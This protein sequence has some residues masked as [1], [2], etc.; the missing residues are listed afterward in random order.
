MLNLTT[1]HYYFNFPFYISKI[2]YKIFSPMTLDNFTK[3]IYTL[4]FG[5]T[6]STMRLCFD[7]FNTKTNNKSEVIQLN[8]IKAVLYHFH[9]HSTTNTDDFE[10][11]I[12]NI[13]TNSFGNISPEKE[14][15]YNEWK[16]ICLK[17]N[18]DV[19]TLMLFYLYRGINVLNEDILNFM[20]KLKPKY[21]TDYVI[22]NAL[23]WGATPKGSSTVTSTTASSS[24]S[25]SNN[26]KELNIEVDTSKDVFNLIKNTQG[27]NME[28]IEE[29]DGNL[30]VNSYE[31]DLETLSAFEEDKKK[32]LTKFT[33][34]CMGL[35]LEPD[36]KYQTITPQYNV[37]DTIIANVNFKITQTLVLPSEQKK[38][39]NSLHGASNI[40][41]SEY[42]HKYE[43]FTYEHKKFTKVKLYIIHSVIFV[44][45]LDKK[46]I[47]L[48]S[49]TS[50][51]GNLAIVF[52]KDNVKLKDGKYYRLKLYQTYD[53]YFLDREKGKEMNRVVCKKLNIQLSNTESNTSTIIKGKYE[54][55]LFNPVCELYN[56][57]VKIYLTKDIYDTVAVKSGKEL[58]VKAITKDA[59]GID[60]N[61]EN[62]YFELARQIITLNIKNGIDFG[63]KPYDKYETAH[64][65]YLIYFVN[66]TIYE[67][68]DTEMAKLSYMKAIT[69]F[70]YY[71]NIFNVCLNI[72]ELT[73]PIKTI[74]S[75]IVKSL[76]RNKST[77]FVNDGCFEEKY[78]KKFV[79]GPPEVLKGEKITRKVDVWWLGNIFYYVLFNK[80]PFNVPD[81]E[82][83]SKRNAKLYQMIIGDVGKLIEEGN[84]DNNNN[85]FTTKMQGL[86]NDMLKV[87]SQSRISIKQI[88]ENIKAFIEEYKQLSLADSQRSK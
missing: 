43:C 61:M 22:F 71:L 79:Y 19:F 15:T 38:L 18:S 46:L 28:Y 5:N 63:I 88:L 87:D 83:E 17:K 73:L 25:S 64:T 44:L 10:T 29:D 1:F 36:N 39:F 75:F 81:E 11:I 42:I 77:K 20:N 41:K 21:P 58:Y 68:I 65:L 82:E 14:I 62:A 40:S 84:N 85:E 66:D 8:N 2:L 45:S 74:K 13:I 86:I 35:P 12:N 23:P 26:K 34:E 72:E 57:K 69:Q 30:S 31:D 7:I 37:E 50:D 9:F 16:N 60:I 54:I 76:T 32:M 33:K 51:W 78:V 49:L 48:I 24:S 70:V 52:N 80:L 47:S 27:M 4:Y 67:Y 56:Q 53:F 3:L 55:D 6:E 59:E